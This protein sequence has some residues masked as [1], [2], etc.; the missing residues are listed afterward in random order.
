MSDNRFDGGRNVNDRRRDEDRSY[1]DRDVEK[2]LHYSV[3]TRDGDKGDESGV[4]AIVKAFVKNPGGAIQIVL[5]I[6]SMYGLYYTMQGE[7]S[8]VKAAQVSNFERLNARLDSLTVSDTQEQVKLDNLFSRGDTRYTNIIA[9]LSSHDV[10]IAKIVAAL[11]YLV[12][13]QKSGGNVE[14]AP[15]PHIRPSTVPAIP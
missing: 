12:D 14:R 13:Q 3:T 4:A 2:D 7:I 5:F 6:G 1:N 10:D 15:P 8:D 11:D 9:K